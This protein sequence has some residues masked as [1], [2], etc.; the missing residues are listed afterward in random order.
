MRAFINNG[1]LYV[2]DV[3]FTKAGKKLV[4]EVATL[5]YGTYFIDDKQIDIGMSG[6]F[7]R[8]SK[9]YELTAMIQHIHPAQGDQNAILEAT[10]K[11]LGLAT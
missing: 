2:V 4:D 1:F 3:P 9:R 10:Q 6:G 11:T 8:R 5:L 7:R